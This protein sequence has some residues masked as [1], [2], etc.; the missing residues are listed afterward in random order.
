MTVPAD[1]FRCPL[2]GGRLRFVERGALEPIL[3]RGTTLDASITGAHVSDAA[4]V[5][6]PYSEGIH[7]FLESDA[8]PIREDSGSSPAAEVSND[9]VRHW[10][11]EFGWARGESG[12]YVDS[13][14]Y[15]A[16]LEGARL[17]EVL[18]HLALV[19]RLGRGDLL[20]DAGCGP[21]PHPEQLEYQREFRHRV[22]VDF[23]SRA[24]AEARDRLGEKGT[25]VQ[26]ELSRLPF[27]DDL[28][29]GAICAYA[30]MHV[31]QELQGAT[32]EELV[33]VTGPG[34]H[35]L[36]ISDNPEPARRPHRIYRDCWRL[37]TGFRRGSR[38]TSQG[39]Y[40]RQ[41]AAPPLYFR[42]PGIPWWR[43]QARRIGV[44][45]S[46]ECQRVFHVEEMELYF[47]HSER[48]PHRFRR[49]EARFRRLLAPIGRYLL[50]D[51]VKPDPHRAA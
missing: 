18:S 28:F 1:D 8:L 25:Y 48:L 50:L 41:A 38:E 15:A 32:V 45:A 35:L 26:A 20:L 4:G 22:C 40:D 11:D 16:S 6:F 9:S 23:S 31:R 29:D 13:E 7:H 12:R 10:Y 37:I 33:R 3:V 30:I 34:R 46:V 2:S 43:D 24:L 39:R 47:N 49:V 21:L 17:Y 42:P 44:R 51:L 27:R 19:E 14:L 36:F 5:A